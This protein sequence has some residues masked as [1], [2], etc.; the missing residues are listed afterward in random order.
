MSTTIGATFSTSFTACKETIV[1]SARW[2]GK[3]ISVNFTNHV[4][5]TTR[6]VWTSSIAFLSTGAG[7]GTLTMLLGFSLILIAEKNLKS[8]KEARIALNILGVALIVAAVASIAL[9]GPAALI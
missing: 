5:P 1:N 6:A 3:K 8:Q 9:I 4:V 7:A 2:C